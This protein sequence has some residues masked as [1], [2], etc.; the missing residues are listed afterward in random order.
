MAT[1]IAPAA[2]V[3]EAAAMDKQLRA[4]WAEMRKAEQT[5]RKAT[6]PFGKLCDKMRAKQAHK[7][8]PKPGSRKGYVS[9]EEYINSVTGRE[10]SRS[11]LYISIA[12][13]KLTEGPNALAPEA[14]AEMPTA[15]AYELYTR[16]RPEQRTPD[17]VEAAK[18]TPKKD[19]PA[20]V[21]AKLNEHLPAEEQKTIRVDF[22]RKLHPTVANKLE[23]TIERFMHLPVTRDGDRA[24]TL[25]EKAIY[26]ICLAAEQFAAEDLREA[27]ETLRIEAL[28]IPDA[29]RATRGESADATK[30]TAAC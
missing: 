12:C 3:R 29:E 26:G 11:T 28:E 14:V 21:Q 8:I 22:F 18:R 4:Q 24:L 9:F 7:Y 15:N 2:R 6:I 30:V 13:Y 5:L 10:I 27:E 25:Q 1:Q 16:L 20:K 17:I 19:F 23:E